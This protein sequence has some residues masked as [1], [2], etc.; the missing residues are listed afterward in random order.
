[1]SKNIANNAGIAVKIPIITLRIN[2]SCPN[3]N[4]PL[5]HNKAIIETKMTAA[6]GITKIEGSTPGDSVKIAATP[7]YKKGKTKIVALAAAIRGKKKLIPEV[8]PKSINGS[9]KS[10]NASSPNPA[11]TPINV[12]IRR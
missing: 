5:L 10:T 2:C 7:I 8:S 12:A 11:A 4:E 6:A 3:H 9:S 1:M